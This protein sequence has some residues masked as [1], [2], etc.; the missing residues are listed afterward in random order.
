MVPPA[1]R[2]KSDNMTSRARVKQMVE[3]MIA[4]LDNQTVFSDD[5]EYDSKYIVGEA[6]KTLLLREHRRVVR[7]VQQLKRQPGIVS[8]ADSSQCRAYKMACED[9][10]A[11]LDERRKG[12]R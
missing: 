12:I 3:K 1:K 8:Y 9:M 5:E 7:M 6:M 10:L 11:C 2:R 4:A